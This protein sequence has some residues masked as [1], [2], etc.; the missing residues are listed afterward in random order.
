[1]DVNVWSLDETD[2]ALALSTQACHDIAREG[3]RQWAPFA[4]VVRSEILA[5]AGQSEAAARA[6]HLAA[7]YARRT[8]TVIWT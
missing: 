8:G 1:M 7:A 4:H 6:Q 3:E 5:A 2:R